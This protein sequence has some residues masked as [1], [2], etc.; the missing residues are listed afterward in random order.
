MQNEKAKI[1]NEFK[2]RLYAFTLNLIEFLDKLPKDSISVRIGDQLLRI[3]TSIIA[4]Y[5]EARAASS[6]KDFTNFLNTSLKSSN[7]SKLWLALLRDRGRI[8]TEDASWFLKNWTR[9]PIFWHPVSWRWRA[10]NS[11][12]FWYV[13]LIFAFWYLIWIEGSN[14][15]VRH[16]FINATT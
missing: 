6:R 12:G 7:E 11:F 8:K 16:T 14:L 13:V 1:K 3:A 10:R 9:Y 5:V 2:R 15:W 4:N